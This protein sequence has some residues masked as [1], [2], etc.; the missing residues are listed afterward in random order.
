MKL[1]L[2]AP[3]AVAAIAAALAFAPIAAAAP[4]GTIT[5]TDTGA[6]TVV[7]SPGNVQVTALPGE[8][9]L[10]AGDLQYPFFGFTPIEIHHLG[11]HRR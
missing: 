6:A 2:I 10:Q 5:T 1:R 3:A 4:T 11:E 9:A 8:A 7:Q